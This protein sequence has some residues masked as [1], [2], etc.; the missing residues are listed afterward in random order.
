M[1]ISD[2]IICLFAVAMVA[3]RK[4][5][6]ET[7]DKVCEILIDMGSCDEDYIYCSYKKHKTNHVWGPS[8]LA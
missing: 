3:W 6:N 8:P 1:I 4:C 5:D 2:I 7:T